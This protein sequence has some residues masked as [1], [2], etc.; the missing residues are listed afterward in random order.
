[1]VESYRQHVSVE[2]QS[3]NT[4][5]NMTE[6]DAHLKLLSSD[7]AKTLY[8]ENQ[9]QYL[10]WRK[11]TMNCNSQIEDDELTETLSATI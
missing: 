10:L 5:D 11:S 4:Y 3:T 9:N 2:L 8:S 7:E 1:M 6:G